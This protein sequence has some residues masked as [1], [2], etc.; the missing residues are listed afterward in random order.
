MIAISP[1]RTQRIRRMLLLVP[2]F[3]L[4]A[5]TRIPRTLDASMDW[6]EIYTVWQSFGSLDQV[7]GWVPY[8]WPPLHYAIVWFW[9]NLVGPHP[10]VQRYFS[11]LVLFLG[12]AFMFALVRKITKHV[13]ASALA[14]LAYIA[15]AHIL[16]LSLLIR[17]YVF[18]YALAPL[19]TYLL[20][21]YFEKPTFRRALLIAVV[22]AAMFYIHL[23]AVIAYLVAG[24]ITFSLL[25]R[26]VW[27]VWLPG[28]LM[29]L[30]A[31]P[32]IL[33]KFTLTVNRSANLV[34]QSLASPVILYPAWYFNFLGAGAPVF[35]VLTLV[36]LLAALTL[37]KYR[38][39]IIALVI[40]VAIPYLS[41]SLARFL[42][43]DAYRHLHVFTFGICFLLA[44]AA[45]R[46]GRN[47]TLVAGAAL[48]AVMLL[49]V[50]LDEFIIYQTPPVL[51]NFEW[52][53]KHWQNGDVMYRDPTTKI[54][55][56]HAWEYFARV[57][58]PQGLPMVTSPVGYRRV[59]YATADGWNLPETKAL[60]EN[61]RIP[62]EY[63]GPWNLL[64]RLYE[65]PPDLV[66]KPF[67]NGLRF[68][69]MDIE[70]SV[71]GQ[72]QV[73][74]ENQTL[75]LK[76]WWSVDHA[77]EA[78][79]SITVQFLNRD[80]ALISQTTDRTGSADVPKETSH[81]EAGRFYVDT[82]IL[83]TPDNSILG[84]GALNGL[85]LQL[86]VYQ[87][88]DGKR[89]GLQYDEAGAPP[90]LPLGDLSIMAW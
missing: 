42:R 10:F 35:V 2:L 84:Q 79:Y 9:Q 7:V 25:G 40:I 24:I 63:V 87:W 65:G 82:L 36:A 54:I 89:I 78:D 68:H 5:L 90:E 31:L 57:Y 22:G 46:M 37:S 21:L 72:F 58:F 50:S 3:L 45:I 39:L 67:A 43:F 34:Q 33:A 62:R 70:G 44:L 75:K 51:Q 23:T 85:P 64:F 81:W 16:Y 53:A 60:V 20:I 73:A 59:W 77:I 12:T 26:R 76:L 27:R 19:L 11:T 66:G 61:G 30:F 41:Y 86:I 69:G 49:P 80:G 28:I 6:D 74:H 29:A 15:P 88:W 32:E 38:R 18:I 8:D 13:P 48:I 14:A 1:P 55:Q 83:T 56:P 17:G 71:T 4:L 47:F 52:L